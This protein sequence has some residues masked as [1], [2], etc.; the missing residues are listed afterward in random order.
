M[1]QK[2]DKH[3]AKVLRTEAKSNEEFGC[4][5]PIHEVLHVR[6]TE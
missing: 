3:N 4:G 6:L 1:K 5:H 2:I